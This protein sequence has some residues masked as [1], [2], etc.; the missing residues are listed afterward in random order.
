MAMH[1]Y[2]TAPEDDFTKEV[3]RLR[4]DY[5]KKRDESNLIRSA[6]RSMVDFSVDWI[7]GVY[8]YTYW[9]T[10]DNGKDSNDKDEG[11]QENLQCIRLFDKSGTLAND[12]LRLDKNLPTLVLNGNYEIL[13]DEIR[14]LETV[15]ALPPPL[16][17]DSEDL[18]AA[19]VSLPV[20]EPDSSKHFLKA[21]KYVSEIQNLLKCQGGSCPGTPVSPHIIQLLGKSPD[22]KLVFNK[23]NTRAVLT[24]IHPLKK[25]KAWI[26]Q[27]ISGLKVLHLLGII[28]RD[29]GIDNTVFSVGDSYHS[30]FIIDLE[31]RWGN[32]QAPEVSH[33]LSMNAGWTEKSDIYDL[34]YLIKGM[35]YG[36]PPVTGA[37]E[38]EWAIPTPLDAIVEACTRKVPEQRP[39]L[40]ELYTMVDRIEIM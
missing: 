4:E 22:G 30:A 17:D 16:E 24:F 2:Q 15:P 7:H 37:V 27:V 1:H 6:G 39:S 12:I 14:V 19:L 25:Y 3:R 34:G 26:L 36:S 18:S 9:Y 10:K 32:Q 35:V 29:L 5:Q 20:V 23:L 31:S 11:S 33:E 40:D 8:C 28:H 13:G 38:L 21:G